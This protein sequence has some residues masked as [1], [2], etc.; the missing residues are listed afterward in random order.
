MKKT[1]I[2]RIAPGAVV[3][4]LAIPMT[5]GAEPLDGRGP[6]GGGPGGWN[7]GNTA[8]R[9]ATATT[10]L[11]AAEQD[12]LE[13]AVLEEYGALNLYSAVL[14]QYPGAFPF[15]RIVRSEQQHVNALLRVADR[16]GVDAP[17]NPGLSETPT[18]ATLQDACAAGVKAEIADAELYDELL[19]VTDNPDVVR[20]YENLQAASLKS[21]LPAFE[22]CD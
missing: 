22:A 10:P 13:L 5:V 8:S 21:H 2:R 6:G 19:E 7:Q 14:E 16:Y 9:Y 3:M 12:A 15:S 20:V 4:A 17:A 18:F 1:W 11:D